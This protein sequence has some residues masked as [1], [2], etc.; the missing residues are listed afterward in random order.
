MCPLGAQSTKGAENKR[1][2]SREEGEGTGNTTEQWE[3]SS[4]I[5]YEQEEV[6]GENENGDEESDG[7]STNSSV[8]SKDTEATDLAKVEF[9]LHNV[10]SCKDATVESV[11]GIR[12]KDEKEQNNSR[13][14]HIVTLG[15]IRT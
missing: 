3:D 2:G 8:G 4:I 1:G 7:D 11:K 12:S 5:E 6:E 13:S 10:L 9:L 15:S 14:F